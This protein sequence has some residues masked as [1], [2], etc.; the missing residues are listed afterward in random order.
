MNTDCVAS[1]EHRESFQDLQTELSE[2]ASWSIFH[3]L[4]S[5][6]RLKNIPLD[7]LEAFVVHALAACRSSQT[8]SQSIHI[9]LTFWHMAGKH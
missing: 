6:S 3:L 4:I 5:S 7:P 8:A 9:L 1:I 2:P